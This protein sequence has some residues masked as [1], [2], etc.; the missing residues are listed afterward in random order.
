ML[1]VAIIGAGDV[2]TTIAYTLQ[3]SG[4]VTEIV[5][6]DINQELAQGHAMDMNHGLFFVSP[7][8]IYAG[9]YSDCSNADVIIVTAGAR[10]KTGESRL[11]LV[12][13]NVQICRSIVEQIKPYNSEGVFLIVTNPVDTITQVVIEYSGL[14]KYRVLGSGTVLDSARFR[15][16][17][18]RNCH[19]DARNVH[20]YVV[21]EHGDS[22]VFLWSQVRIAGTPLEIFC[23]SCAN[24]C[25]S[26]N[27]ERIAEAVR[28]SAYHIIEA[29]GATNYGVSL[30]VRRI[31]EAVIRDESSVLTV[32]TWLGGEYGLDGICLSV[33]CIINRKGV[34][35]V[36]ETSLDQ[37]EEEGIK[38]SA[39][40]LR[41]I[42]KSVVR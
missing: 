41:D 4:L 28:N 25:N 37:S 38:K 33:P 3:L 34:K 14:P 30:A 19:V 36:V 18:S 40:I 20:A 15:Y 8:H 35:Q 42:Y 11:Q 26:I 10:Q 5:L 39:E 17:L 23:K 21:G 29:K 2:G 1:K 32:S 22:E 7:V 13:R 6:V 24:E 16:F 31:V 12:G 9:K 27:K